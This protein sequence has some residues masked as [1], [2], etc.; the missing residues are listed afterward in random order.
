MTY[1]IPNLPTI[2]KTVEDIMIRLLE[3]S[4]RLYKP[5][6]YRSPLWQEIARQVKIRDGWRCQKCGTS[7][8]LDVHHRRKISEGG[9]NHPNNL[10]TLCRSCHGNHHPERRKL[11]YGSSTN[12]PVDTTVG[13]PYIR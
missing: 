7:K 1:A 4:G 10:I 9:T 5:I 8:T 2:S 12:Q 6:P 3:Q 13:L 11:K